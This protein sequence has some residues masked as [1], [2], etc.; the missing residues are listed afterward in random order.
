M[1]ASPGIDV[2]FYYLTVSLKCTPSF[3]KKIK[4]NKI[5]IGFPINSLVSVWIHLMFSVFKIKKKKIV[6]IYNIQ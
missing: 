1:G 4:Q 2:K 5:S 6:V 3:L